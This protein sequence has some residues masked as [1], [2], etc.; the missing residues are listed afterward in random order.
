VSKLLNTTRKLTTLERTKKTIQNKRPAAISTANKN[1]HP[2]VQRTK[3]VRHKV[4]ITRASRSCL[5]HPFS[6]RVDD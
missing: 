3:E 6:R 4:T 5:L 2:R 1:S